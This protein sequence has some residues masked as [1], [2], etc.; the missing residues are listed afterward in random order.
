MTPGD[1]SH[2]SASSEPS[3]VE[4][5]PDRGFDD[6]LEVAVVDEAI[7]QRRARRAA[8][9]RDRELAT[10]DGTLRDLAERTTTVTLATR[11]G[12]SHR[13]VVVTV[14]TDHLV[15]RGHDAA[16]TA[17][18]GATIVS[19]RPDPASPVAATSADGRRPPPSEA[20]FLEVLDRWREDGAPCLAVLA[21]GDT[22]RGELTTVG[23]DVVSL[24]TSAGTVHVPAS[25]LVIVTVR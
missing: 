22:E 2:P 5:A 18:R 13:G 3:A 11:A 21:S 10:W 8:R 6:L 16:L 20:R 25:A 15:L 19:A 4:P 12:T 24:R 9:D 1:P 23:E 17:I 7:R 14:A